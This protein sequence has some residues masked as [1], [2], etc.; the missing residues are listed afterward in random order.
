[1]PPALRSLA[2]LVGAAAMVG[3]AVVGRGA[4][5]SKEERDNLRLTVVCDPLARAFCEAAAAADPRITPRFEPPDETTRRLVALAA[6]ERPD[7]QA[8]VSVGPWLQMADGRRTGQP[9]LDV[10]TEHVAST[11]I[12]LVTK[13]GQTLP[14][15]SKPPAG[16][17]PLPR[18]R[19]GLASPRVSGVGLAGLTQIVLASTGIPVNDLDR[20]AV[21]SG[22]AATTIDAVARSSDPN[23][24]LGPQIAANFSLANPVV[25]TQAAAAAVADRVASIPSQPAVAAVLQIGLLDQ[26]A[27]VPLRGDEPAG[28]ALAKKAMEDGWGPAHDPGGGLPEP[29]VLAAVQD[30]WRGR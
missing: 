28:R 5:D 30:A 18:N 16:C 17:L 3:A 1:M 29:G 15:C 22:P 10:R 23:D 11:P 24:S 19:V 21:E 25:T 2:A 4:L 9:P 26:A 14:P 8:W 7:F 6:G 20:A 13:L 12:V 27:V